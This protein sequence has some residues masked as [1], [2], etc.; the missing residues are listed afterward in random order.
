MTT[1]HRIHAQHTLLAAPTVRPVRPQP[2]PPVRLTRRGR[3]TAITLGTLII[4]SVLALAVP[5]PLHLPNDG[6]PAR[7][8]TSTS[9]AP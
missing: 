6:S 8:S 2:A 4:G 7:P 3:T 5:G 9:T 1:A